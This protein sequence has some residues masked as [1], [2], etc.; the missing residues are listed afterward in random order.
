MDD[1]MDPMDIDGSSY[2]GTPLGKRSHSAFEA[3]ENM[4]NQPP[5][6]IIKGVIYTGWEYPDPPK[7]VR[8]CRQFTAFISTLAAHSLTAASQSVGFLASGWNWFWGIAATPAPTSQPVEIVAVETTPDGNKRRAIVRDKAD[9]PPTYSPRTFQKMAQSQPASKD[10]RKAR[11]QPQPSITNIPAPSQPKPK[12]ISEAHPQSQPSTTNIMAQSQ[13]KPK[14]THQARAQPQPHTTLPTLRPSGPKNIREAMWPSRTLHTTI[15]SRKPAITEATTQMKE[16]PH[17]ALP[18]P[19]AMSQTQKLKQEHQHIMSGAVG[20][21]Q[22]G[23]HQPPP[24]PFGSLEPMFEERTDL[25]HSTQQLSLNGQE[26]TKSFN[27]SDMLPSQ[28]LQAEMTTPPTEESEKLYEPS[29][30]LPGAFPDAT[31]ATPPESRPTSSQSK[32]TETQQEAQID[33]EAAKSTSQH[34]SSPHVQRAT[35]PTSSRVFAFGQSDNTNTE[36]VGMSYKKLIDHHPR[37]KA[38]Q[39]ARLG[40]SKVPTPPPSPGLSSP[41]LPRSARGAIGLLGS[42]GQDSKKKK[43]EQKQKDAVLQQLVERAQKAAIEPPRI[44]DLRE[45]LTRQTLKERVAKAEK[46]KSDQEAKERAEEEARVQAEIAEELRQ[47]AEREAAEEEE[48]R[49]R[50]EAKKALLIRPLDPEWDARVAAALATTNKRQ[51]LAKTVEGVDLSRGDFGRIIPTGTTADGD[52]PSGW[53]N[54]EA[55]N[56]WFAAI[57]KRKEAQTGYKKG[58]NSVPAMAAY[59]SSWYTTV[60]SRGLDSIKSWSRRKG[61]QGA[62]LLKAEKIFFP[63]CTGGHWVLLIISPQERTIEYLDSLHGRGT[64]FFDMARDWLAMELGDNLYDDEEWV[65]SEVR[66]SR[67]QNSDDCGIFTCINGLAAAKGRPFTEV[68]SVNGMDEARRLVAAVLLNGGFE[69]DFEL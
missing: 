55:I 22:G 67:Q 7:A 6:P 59:N 54:D 16:K 21:A 19:K 18:K 63:L 30:T 44:K 5:Q 69:G 65:D 45:T 34:Q 14:D 61:I 1:S 37:L 29:R 4:P 53:L 27:R 33:E 51:F 46:E 47:Q 32:Q 35:R 20:S 68:I 38:L 60:R 64:K 58:V 25:E 10:T 3:D 13:P 41:G 12:D 36:G 66:S 39:D 42:Q 9:E 8:Y 57:V 24:C 23:D 2:I 11:A 31:M 40:E 56:G 52:G 17:R 28:L 50:D 15:P 43:E 26:E 48:R 62:K 49:K